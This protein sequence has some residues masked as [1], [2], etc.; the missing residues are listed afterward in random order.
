MK[1]KKTVSVLSYSLLIVFVLINIISIATVYL[2]T[3][4]IKLVIIVSLFFAISIICVLVHLAIVRREL[5]YF[6]NEICKVIDQMLNNKFDSKKI[7]GDETIFNK[8]QS[9][10]LKLYRVLFETK[11]KTKKDEKLLKELISDISHQVKTP[12]TNLKMINSLLIKDEISKEER[13]IFLRE[14]NGQLDNLEFL[15]DSMIKTS[16]LETD[17]ISLNKKMQIIYDTIVHALGG[18]YLDSEKKNINIEINCSETFMFPHDYKWTSEAIFN[19]LENAVK[20]T[21]KNGHIEINVEEWEL[22]VKIDIKDNGIG[23]SEREQAEIFKRFYR[24]QN[25]SDIK[26]VGLGLYL[27]R[28]IIT[29][30]GGYIMVKSDFNEGSKFSIFLPKK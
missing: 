23:I 5:T 30:Q 10:L 13:D 16:R 3:N 27:S 20:Y 14:S 9:R 6:S 28:E 4:N 19:I 18:I 2:E 12:M 11:E 8:I 7:L 17:V 29:K 25:I 15:I 22:Y 21:D 1:S 26:G 24:G